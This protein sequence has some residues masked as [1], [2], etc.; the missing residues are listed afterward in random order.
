MQTIYHS[1]LLFLNQFL[2]L[3]ED[4]FTILQKRTAVKHFNK[5]ENLIEPGET[6]KHLYFTGRGLI[7]EYFIRGKK[8]VTTDII[9]EGTITGS[10]SSFLTGEPSH[11]CLQA[12]EPVTVLA[13]SRIDLEELYSSDRKW[14]RLGRVLTAH[15]LLQQEQ[16]ILDNIRFSVRERFVHFA[17]K[18]RDL[19]QRVPQKYLASY[20]NIE[21][22]TFSRLKHLLKKNKSLL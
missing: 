13:I 15:F 4:E 7:R 9:T 2:H 21:P 6:D 18:H 1:L 16:H 22:E 12:M 14:E 8:Q 11:Y 3:S 17:E 20:L 5:K 10:I 19:L